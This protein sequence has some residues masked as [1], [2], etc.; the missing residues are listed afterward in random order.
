MIGMFISMA[1]VAV[2][3]VILWRRGPDRRLSQPSVG[4][5]L[6]VA[7]LVLLGAQV[8]FYLFFAFGEMF[9]G[10]L[11]GAGHL[12]PAAATALLAWLAWRRPLE[13]GIALLVSGLGVALAVRGGAA[14]LIMAAPF[15]VAGV[16]LL[17]GARLA[18]RQSKAS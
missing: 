17:I 6:G 1:A 4:R 3:A 7:A 9:S 5:W 15:L 16:L 2:L 14:L 11:S 8:A 12:A 13:G 18:A 10:D